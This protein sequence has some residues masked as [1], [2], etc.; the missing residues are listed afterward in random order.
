M[1]SGPNA[2]LNPNTQ[3]PLLNVFDLNRQVTGGKLAFL[4]QASTVEALTRN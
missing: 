3:N 2:R 1:F 4:G